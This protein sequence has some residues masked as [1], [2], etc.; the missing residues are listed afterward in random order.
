MSRNKLGRRT[1]LHGL[2]VAAAT[3]PFLKY[4]PSAVAQTGQIPKRF[5]VFFTPNEPINKSFWKTASMA[6]GQPLLGSQLHSVMSPLVPHVSK[7]TMIGDLEMKVSAKDA[8]SGG[9][10]GIGWML[11]GYK[12][13]ITDASKNDGFLGGGISVDQFIANKWGVDTLNLA[14]RSGGGGGNGFLSYKAAG[15]KVDPFADPKAAFDSIFAGFQG[16]PGDQEAYK[17]Q[18]RLLLDAVSGNVSSLRSKLPQAD[19]LKL[20]QQLEAIATLDAN[21]DKVVSCESTPEAPEAVVINNKNFPKI[22]RLHIDVMVQAL[23]CNVT[24]VGV[25]QLGGSGDLK[26]NG[27]PEWPEEGVVHSSNTHT[28]SHDFY[29]LAK[30]NNTTNSGYI[31]RV[32]LEKFYYKQFA[33]LLAQLDAVPEGDGTLLDNTLVLWTKNIGY[34]H[35]WSEMLFMLAGGGAGILPQQ[36]RYLSFSG[37]AHN[38]LLATIC[39]KLGISMTGFGDPDYSG[40]LAI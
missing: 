2:G 26:E 38:K 10:R 11:T 18:R 8:G 35:K 1:M 20:D 7:L 6:H 23:A 34:N 19:Q 9:H 27:V 5:V 15:Q 36:G 37:Q 31:Q 4:M 40:T 17:A 29:D 12:N 3:L 22:G 24:R 39:N 21:L 28:L 13:N 16:T 32:N 33:Y 14:A 25:V 30:N